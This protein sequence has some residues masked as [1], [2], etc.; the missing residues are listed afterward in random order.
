[1]NRLLRTTVQWLKVGFIS[2][3]ILCKR[4]YIKIVNPRK[5]FLEHDPLK[6]TENRNTNYSNRITQKRSC[7]IEKKK[8]SNLCKNVNVSFVFFYRL[9][10]LYASPRGLS[11]GPPS[12]SVLQSNGT[13]CRARVRRLLIRGTG[14]TAGTRVMPR[15]VRRSGAHP[16]TCRA[17]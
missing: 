9:Q 17:A 3:N 13:K 12:K 5:P 10:N 16:A 8:H 11:L 2:M 6:I 7:I 1:M 14:F 4:Y 15:R